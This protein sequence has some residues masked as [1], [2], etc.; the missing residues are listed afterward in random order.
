MISIFFFAL[1]L[2]GGLLALSLLGDLVGGDADLGA[3]ADLGIGVG[4]DLDVAS[5][6]DVAPEMAAG[7]ASPSDAAVAHDAAGELAGAIRILTIRNLTYFLFGFGGV[8]SFLHWFAPGLEPWLVT[9]AALLGGLVVG[10]TSAVVFGWLR[11]TD[12]GG[13]AGED[14]F[15]GCEGRV[16]LPLRQGKIGQ[17]VVLRGDREHELRALPFDAGATAPELWRQVVVIEMEGGTARVAPMESLA[18]AD[19]GSANP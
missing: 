17:V 10:G 5:D 7:A 14:T 16:V 9:G 3:D 15:V 13:Q 8:G 1:V 6:L 11:A 2:G 19:S 12:A 18:P 4:T